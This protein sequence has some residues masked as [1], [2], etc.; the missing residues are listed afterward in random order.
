MLGGVFCST[1]YDTVWHLA[2]IVAV[3]FFLLCFFD[4]S[5]MMQSFCLVLGL[6]ASKSFY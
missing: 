5:Y 2:V 3:P 6:D 4:I 1:A